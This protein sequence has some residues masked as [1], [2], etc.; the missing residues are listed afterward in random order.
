MIEAAFHTSLDENDIKQ[1][2]F[3]I[4]SLVH[5]DQK[6]REKK[7]PKRYILIWIILIRYW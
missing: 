5:Y 7:S 2:T 1:Q 4:Y 3:H 6:E